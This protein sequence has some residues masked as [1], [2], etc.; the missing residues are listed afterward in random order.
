MD[1]ERMIAGLLDIPLDEVE[2]A[3]ISL[4]EFFVLMTYI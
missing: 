4:D 1:V 2:T 3:S